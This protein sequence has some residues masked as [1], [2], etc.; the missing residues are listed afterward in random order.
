MTSS[1]N[2][3]AASTTTA[4]RA[5]GA[6]RGFTLRS[7]LSSLPSGRDNNDS[8]RNNNNDSTGNDD[9]GAAM[10]ALLLASTDVDVDMGLGH[11]MGHGAVAS[12]NASRPLVVDTGSAHNSGDDI[13]TNS[14]HC[15]TRNA[16]CRTQ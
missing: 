12:P 13:A 9:D 7:T 11:E 5:A 15:Q 4:R 10:L 8:M 6:G 3:A 16:V 1:A 2:D 14:C